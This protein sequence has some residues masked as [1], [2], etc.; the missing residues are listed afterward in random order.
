MQIYQYIFA[1]DR[2]ILIRDTLI[3]DSLFRVLSL[4]GWGNYAFVNNY[5]S[6]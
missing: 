4:T 2:N 5:E 6:T 1:V 3:I